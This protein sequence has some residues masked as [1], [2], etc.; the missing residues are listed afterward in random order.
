[1]RSWVLAPL[2]FNLNTRL[3]RVVTS[4]SGRF[5]T[6]KRPGNA[7]NMGLG[8]P[9]WRSGPLW[10]ETN[11]FGSRNFWAVWIFVLFCFLTSRELLGIWSTVSFQGRP[12]CCYSIPLCGRTRARLDPREGKCPADT[13]DGL[14]SVRSIFTWCVTVL[15]R[16]SGPASQ[17]L[18]VSWV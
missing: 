18:L 5:T 10:E 15:P 6:R 14:I 4:R 11:L 16:S 2:I 3:K 13:A 9:H 7:L 8:G 12:W 1:M 17:L